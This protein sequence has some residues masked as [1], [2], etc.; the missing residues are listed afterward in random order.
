MLRSTGKP[1]QPVSSLK[2]GRL[3]R[4]GELSRGSDEG[5]SMKGWTVGRVGE[6]SGGG[7]KNGELAGGSSMK[8]G[9]LGRGS[10]MKKSELSRAGDDCRSMVGSMVGSVGK[11]G[12]GG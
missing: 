12:K 10:G 11:P 2:S 8:K 4:R 7:V 3:G 9:E 6:L 1:R 5:A